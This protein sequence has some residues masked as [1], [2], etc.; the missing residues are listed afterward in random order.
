MQLIKLF[1]FVFAMLLIVAGALIALL[2]AGRAE[3]VLAALGLALVVVG[4]EAFL[5]AAAVFRYERDDLVEEVTKRLHLRL[6]DRPLGATGIRRIT[7]ARRGCEEYYKWV[8]STEPQRLFFAGRSVLHRIDED[9][10]KLEAGPA[11]VALARMVTEGASVRILFVNPNS[12]LIERL[13][14]DE[15]QTKRDMVSDLA[16]SVGICRR[17]HGLLYN[18]HIP[19]KAELDIRVFDAVPYF[20]YHRQDTELIIGFYFAYGL[21]GTSPAY[22]VLDA[23]TQ[24]VFDKHFDSLWEDPKTTASLLSSHKGVLR[25]DEKLMEQIR[26]HISAVLGAERAAELI[27]EP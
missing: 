23:A 19:N 14:H 5:R 4:V 6:L 25:I 20:A 26:N 21:G 3:K 1:N 17:L 9:L 11:E 8:M 10:K 27:E 2:A 16:R 12:D 7:D 22:E 24:G 15:R 13:A 18:K